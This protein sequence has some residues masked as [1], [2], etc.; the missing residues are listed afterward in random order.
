MLLGDAVRVPMNESEAVGSAGVAVVG[1][2]LARRVVRAHP[3]GQGCIPLC[4]LERTPHDESR[5]TGLQYRHK[6]NR[7]HEETKRHDHSLLL[8]RF[9]RSADS[10]S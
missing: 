5:R 4:Q 1:E 3:R 10:R 2:G 8:P 7:H 9:A 6:R